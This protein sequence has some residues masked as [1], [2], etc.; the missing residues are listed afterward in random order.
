MSGT[1][2]P[3]VRVVG[4]RVAAKGLRCQGLLAA[5]ALEQVLLPKAQPPA[6]AFG[7]GL[8]PGLGAAAQPPAVAFGPALAPALG[9]A[10]QPP[11]VALRCH[12]LLL[13]AAVLLAHLDTDSL[14]P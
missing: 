2:L 13:P 12:D 14:L 6:V 10:A 5:A 4:R 3:V 9:A 11:A 8:G 7:P 1:V